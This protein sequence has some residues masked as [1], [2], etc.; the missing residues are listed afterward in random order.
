MNPL[1][2][3]SLKQQTDSIRNHHENVRS[4]IKGKDE[5]I[6]SEG[7][8]H[9]GKAI[10]GGFELGEILGGGSHR[11]LSIRASDLIQGEGC[12]LKRRDELYRRIGSFGGVVVMK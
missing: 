6:K 9:F 12:R 1:L 8:P 10:D 3:F 11:R 2:S 4:T 5:A 7:G